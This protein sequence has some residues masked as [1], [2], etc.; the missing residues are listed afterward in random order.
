MQQFCA[1]FFLENAVFMQRETRYNL[2]IGIHSR[3]TL[4]RYYL[5]RT[6]I[7]TAC[8]PANPFRWRCVLQ[9]IYR[10]EKFLQYRLSNT[11]NAK[12]TWSDRRPNQFRFSIR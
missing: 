10:F 11:V 5:R 2:Y 6:F 9:C 3:F 4:L 12:V 7:D 8:F 1:H